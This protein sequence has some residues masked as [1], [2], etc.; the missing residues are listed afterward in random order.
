MP[1]NGKSPRPPL[2]KGEKKPSVCKQSGGIRLMPQCRGAPR[3]HQLKSPFGEGGLQGD[4]IIWLYK[5]RP[6][7]AGESPQGLSNNW[8]FLEKRVL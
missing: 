5:K 7:D 4:F 2:L 3:R 8:R 1:E 6:L